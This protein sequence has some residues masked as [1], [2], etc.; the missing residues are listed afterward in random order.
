MNRKDRTVR[1]VRRNAVSIRIPA[2]ALR[3]AGRR[4]ADVDLPAPARTGLE[5]CALDSCVVVDGLPF[6]PEAFNTDPGAAAEQFS[7]AALRARRLP[8]TA[9]ELK[10]CEVPP[11]SEKTSALKP[12]TAVLSARP[13]LTPVW[14]PDG[15]GLMHS[16][17]Y[18]THH[19][20]GWKPF[21]PR[22]HHDRHA[23]EKESVTA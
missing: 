9:E 17:C 20:A 4:L 3:A 21:D 12:T 14:C 19:H 16:V 18:S 23:T 7:T 11:Q 15:C 1:T 8:Y 6:N 2:W 22:D 5:L 10:R 13:D